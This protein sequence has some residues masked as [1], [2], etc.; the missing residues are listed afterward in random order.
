MKSI[1]YS[2]LSHTMLFQGIS[3]DEVKEML[4]CLSAKIQTFQKNETIYHVGACVSA[5]GIVLNGSVS[6]ENDER[7]VRDYDVAE[8]KFKSGRANQD[9][10]DEHDKELKELEAMEKKEGKSKLNE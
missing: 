5:L 2:F 8:L 6:L 9:K 3:E 10:T 4:S 1:D 7:E